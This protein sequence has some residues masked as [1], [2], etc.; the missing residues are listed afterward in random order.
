MLRVTFT[1]APIL[2]GIDKFA[3][4]LTN[5]WTRYLATEFNDVIPGSAAD[6]MHAVGVIEIVAGPVVAPRPR[7]RGGIVGGAGGGG[8]AHPLLGWGGAVDP[9]RHLLVPS[10]PRSMSP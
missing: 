10:A 7:L 6:A 8:T 4:A 5:D 9:P 3:N 2:F 1:V